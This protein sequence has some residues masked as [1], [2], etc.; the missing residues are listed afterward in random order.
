MDSTATSQLSVWQPAPRRTRPRPR[1]VPAVPRL[2]VVVVNYLRWQD[3]ATLVR[4]LRSTPAL[5]H[6][7]AEVIIVDN[8]SPWDPLIAQLRRMPGVSL[9]RWHGNRGFARAVNEGVRLSRGDWVLLLNPDMS[10]EGC[11]LDKALA[12]AE[13]LAR[14]DTHT[15]IIGFGLRDGDRSCQ[16]S[17][18]PFPSLA[19]S[20][21]RLL[22]P[23]PWRKYYLRATTACRPVDWVTG[24]CL[25]V[26]RTCWE[27]LGGLDD[28]FFLYYEDVDLCRRAR[29]RGWTVWHEPSLSATHHHPLHGRA[30]PSHLRLVTRHA[31]LTY[32]R[33]HWPR[34]QTRILAGIIRVEAWWRQRLAWHRGDDL[35]AGLFDTLGRMVRDF[36][37]GR[38]AAAGRHLLR[39]VR[40]REEW[41]AAMSDH[42]DPQS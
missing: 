17:A 16:R 24:C 10:L 30:V 12:R 27:N 7:A 11:F 20:L 3:T 4:Q 42:C 31:L 19:S 22:L 1:L 5:R 41:R 9:R 37:R 38:I 32:A 40:R 26:R 29:E 39:V 35:R 18:G 28:A 34:W 21:A 14:A 15:G 13:E 23:R 2:S 6:G 36:G 8:D 33:K 25:L